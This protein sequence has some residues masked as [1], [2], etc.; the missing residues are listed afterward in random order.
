MK[1][2]FLISAI[3]LLIIAFC[4]IVYLILLII[5]YRRK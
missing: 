4:D 2:V 3:T 1:I 5:E